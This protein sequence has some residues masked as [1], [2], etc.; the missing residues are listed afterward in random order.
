MLCS[1]IALWGKGK[2]DA[3]TKN[4]E[5]ISKTLSN[6]SKK[7]LELV[8]RCLEDCF[9]TGRIWDSIPTLVHTIKKPRDRIPRKKP[10]RAKRKK[11]SGGR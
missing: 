8:E 11:Q 5:Q 2:L 3:I 9:E 1:E 4:L 6:L 10:R 7:E